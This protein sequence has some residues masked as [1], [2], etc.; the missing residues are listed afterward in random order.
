M[1]LT[2]F[3]DGYKACPLCGAVL[4]CILRITFS[5]GTIYELDRKNNMFV[6]CNETRTTSYV[7]KNVSDLHLIPNS[8]MVA[9]TIQMS[10][11]LK[12]L[13][14]S[15]VNYGTSVLQIECPIRDFFYSSLAFNIFDEQPDVNFS[16]SEFIIDKNAIFNDYV[17]KTTTITIS[18]SFDKNVNLIPLDRWP[19]SNKIK[20]LEKIEKLLVLI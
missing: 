13:K 7:K 20:L 6:R 12:F 16:W 8:F 17:E 5:R 14:N 18:D 4:D 15:S 9:N 3:F 2:E 11:S 10:E 19:L 1:K